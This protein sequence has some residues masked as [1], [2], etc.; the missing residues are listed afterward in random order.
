MNDSTAMAIRRKQMAD[1]TSGKNLTTIVLNEDEM[2]ALSTL[3]AN[4]NQT[5]YEANYAL[6]EALG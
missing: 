5:D 3:L 2:E 1:V 6:C 4:A